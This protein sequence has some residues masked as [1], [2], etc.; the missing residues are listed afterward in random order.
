MCTTSWDSCPAGCP[1]P[2]LHDRVSSKYGSFGFASVCLPLIRL[3][4]IFVIRA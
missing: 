4:L 3:Q 2:V 1:W